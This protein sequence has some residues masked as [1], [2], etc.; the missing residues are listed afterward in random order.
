MIIKQLTQIDKN[1]VEVFKRLIPQLVGRNDYPSF[2]SLNDIINSKNVKLLVAIDNDKIIGSLSIAIY[3]IPTGKKAIIEDVIVDESARGKG[4]A[5]RLM[6]RAIEI[7]REN[8]VR[9]IELTS[10]PTRIAANKMYVK[11]GFKVR[12]T[13]FYRLDLE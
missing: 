1:T 2:E 10:N 12:D 11:Y 4:V 7:A 8:G 3:L 9:K 5:S 6:D 13:N